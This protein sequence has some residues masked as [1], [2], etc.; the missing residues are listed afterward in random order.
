MVWNLDISKT[1]FNILVETEY[2][3]LTDCSLAVTMMVKNEKKRIHVTLNSIVKYADALIIYDTGSTDNTIDIIKYHCQKHKINLYMISGEFTNFG[4]SRSTLLEYADTVDATYLLLMDVNDELRGGDKLLELC[5]QEMKTDTTG[6]L[7]S[8]HWWSGKYDTYFNIRFLKNRSGWRYKGVVHEWLKD[9]KQEGDRPTY[10]VQKMT[11]DILLYQDRT[12]D[13]DKT[14]KRFHRDKILL[15]KEYKKNKRDT[16]TVFYLAQT[17]AC[18]GHAEDAFYYYKV[19]SELDGFQEE[20]F[21]SLLRCGDLSIKLGH[22]WYSTLAWYMKALEHSPRAEPLVKIAHYYKFTKKWILAYMFLDLACK[23][24][25]PETSILFV[26]KKLYDYD[27]WH[28]MG[29][30]AYYSNNLERGKDAC[31]R[32]LKHGGDNEIDIKN[33]E[34]YTKKLDK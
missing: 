1:K 13:D 17:C 3:P 34:F 30:I 29:I 19:R 27:R 4:E 32:A 22:E 10:P 26:D 33:L 15:L 16:R 25:F 6:Y 31:L 14:G 2:K 21:H 20:K 8:Q 9:T 12:K 28:L 18:L 5:K 24:P 23:L 11:K 7:T